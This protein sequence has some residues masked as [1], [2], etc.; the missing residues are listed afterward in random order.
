MDASSFTSELVIQHA[1]MDGG[2]I[3]VSIQAYDDL[4][5]YKEGTI[6][7]K[8]SSAKLIPLACRSLINRATNSGTSIV[9]RSV[10]SR[11]YRSASDGF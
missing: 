1:I 3:V 7:S 6:Y 11:I 5:K 10:I 4:S 2:P 9:E 8:S